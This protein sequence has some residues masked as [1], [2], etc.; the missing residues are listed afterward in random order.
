M[1]IIIYTEYCIQY[2]YLN[3]SPVTNTVSSMSLHFRPS[4]WSILFDT[5]CQY[6]PKFIVKKNLPPLL[7]SFI[8]TTSYLLFT[9]FFLLFLLCYIFFFFWY[10]FFNLSFRYID[11]FINFFLLFKLIFLW[12]WELTNMVALTRRQTVCRQ[13]LYT[14]DYHYYLFFFLSVFLL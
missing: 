7:G 2:M 3:V 11:V 6:T 5:M 13:R 14:R 10:V 12:I 9:H 8:G 4:L 1:I